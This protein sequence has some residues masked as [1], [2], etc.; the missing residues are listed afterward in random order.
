[1]VNK[2]APKLLHIL[3]VQYCKH[4]MELLLRWKLWGYWS[5]VDLLFSESVTTSLHFDIVNDWWCIYSQDLITEETRDSFNTPFYCPSYAEIKEA[6]D[7]TSAFHIKALDIWQDIDFLPKSEVKN[8]IA[9]PDVYGTMAMNMAKS[10]LH[11]LVEAHIG[12]DMASTLWDRVE[13]HA[14]ADCQRNK[15]VF[16]CNSPGANVA[17][18]ILVKK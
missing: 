18:A 6:V 2:G 1:M 7:A 16:F 11:S 3:M 10:L 15:A 9:K 4:L 5:V 17:L 8:L 14:I 13:T 12:A